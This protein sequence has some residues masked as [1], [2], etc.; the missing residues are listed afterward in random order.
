MLGLGT[1]VVGEMMW[2]RKERK[3]QTTDVYIRRHFFSKMDEKV[4]VN[5]TKRI[6]FY[7]LRKT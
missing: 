3:E 6:I 5:V 7:V 2:G 4:H 1:G